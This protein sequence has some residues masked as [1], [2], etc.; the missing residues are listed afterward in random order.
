VYCIYYKIFYFL[1]AGI[2]NHGIHASTYTNSCTYLIAAANPE[3]G[4]LVRHFLADFVSIR[5]IRL[6]VNHETLSLGWKV[7]NLNFN[8]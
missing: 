5:R 1:S 4:L 7:K 3:L 2:A 6:G 8:H